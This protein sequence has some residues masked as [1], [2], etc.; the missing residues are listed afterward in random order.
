M[1]LVLG[2][3]LAGDRQRAVL[4]L[5]RHVGLRQAGQVRLQQEVVLGLDEV[6]RRDPAATLLTVGGA[7]ERVEKP[8]DVPG[9][10]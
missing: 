7:E 8:I 3:A 5:D 9:K 1:R 4:N 6:H 2:A 10:T